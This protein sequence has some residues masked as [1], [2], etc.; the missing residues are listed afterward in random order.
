MTSEIPLRLSLALLLLWSSACGRS[1]SPESPAS[2][3]IYDA[4]PAE[5][6]PAATYVFYLHGQLIED[7]GRRPTHPEFGL[8]EYDEILRRLAED[9]R[10]VVSE[11][12]AK[13]TDPEVYSDKV[14]GQIEALLAGGVPGRQITVIGVSKGAVI[15]MLVSTKVRSPEVGY[16]ILAN[17]NDWVTEH[18]L[19]GLHGQV[20]SIYEATDSV[21]GTCRPIFAQS[22]QIGSHREI[23]LETGLRH[24]FLYRP[25]KEW[26][27]P[28]IAWTRR[29]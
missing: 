28:A 2:P 1:K 15:A 12:R 27:E 14:A 18:F 10:V 23:R 21:G 25:L 24:G 9:G 13:D 4:P 5:S 6:G 20:L 8:Y 11:A 29:R 26:I 3:R 16:V 7:Q 22:K 19:I 17:C